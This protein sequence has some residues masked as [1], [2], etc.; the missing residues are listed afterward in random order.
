MNGQTDRQIDRYSHSWTDREPV[1]QFWIWPSPDNRRGSFNKLPSDPAAPEWPQRSRT[2][3]S[4]WSIWEII[5]DLPP[6]PLLKPPA[7][8]MPGEGQPTCQPL[9]TP[10]S[11]HT[12]L[13]QARRMLQWT[14]QQWVF[15]NESLFSKL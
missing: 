10:P 15:V 6:V 12:W 2:H 8:T 14:R 11:H 5:S 4:D 7:D 1:L 3:T 13:A 9:L